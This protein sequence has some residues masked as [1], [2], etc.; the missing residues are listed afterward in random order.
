MCTSIKGSRAYQDEKKPTKKELEDCWEWDVGLHN[1]RFPHLVRDLYNSGLLSKL[2]QRYSPSKR[3]RW[4]Q[5]ELYLVLI[6]YCAMN[7]LTGDHTTDEPA[8]KRRKTDSEA[9]DRPVVEFGLYFPPH[10][11]ANRELPKDMALLS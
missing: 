9:A 11:C 7:M 3:A 5:N 10:K 4:T 8:P 1:P 6:A 2:I